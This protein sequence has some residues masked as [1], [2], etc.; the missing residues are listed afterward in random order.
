MPATHETRVSAPRG[1]IAPEREHGVVVGARRE[2]RVRPSGETATAGGA[3]EPAD[4][5]AVGAARTSLRQPDAGRQLRQRSRVS[6]SRWNAV[7]VP[8]AAEVT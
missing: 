3:R 4:R 5:R 1:R 8:A 6:T 2:R 7:S